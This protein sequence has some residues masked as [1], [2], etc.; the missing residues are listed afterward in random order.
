MVL[1]LYHV[2][3]TAVVVV[4]SVE[5]SWLVLQIRSGEQQT[6]LVVRMI[7]NV[8]NYDYILD[9][10]FKR[11]GSIAVGVRFIRFPLQKAAFVF[12]SMFN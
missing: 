3:F 1:V 9:W 12:Q 6:T 8:G 2:Y 7:A 10:E 4:P 5:V 11:S